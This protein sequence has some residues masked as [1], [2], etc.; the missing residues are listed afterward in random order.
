MVTGSSGSV[1]ILRG[2][3]TDPEALAKNLKHRCSAVVLNTRD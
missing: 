3:N 1:W 2:D